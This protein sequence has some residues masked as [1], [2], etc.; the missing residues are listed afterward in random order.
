MSSDFAT[1]LP[2]IK[3]AI[4]HSRDCATDSLFSHPLFVVLKAYCV[5][6]HKSSIE[7]WGCFATNPAC[8]PP[9]EESCLSRLPWSCGW[10]CGSSATR[11][12]NFPNPYSLEASTIWEIV[13]ID[14]SE[15]TNFTIR[16][17]ACTSIR[18]CLFSKLT[19][20]EWWIWGLLP[21]VILQVISWSGRTVRKKFTARHDST[22]SA[23]KMLTLSSHISI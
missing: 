14:K 9:F 13:S 23:S 1:N 21:S 2:Y 12:V 18:C 8:A 4:H 17:V 5:S 6:R 7:S 22:N 20:P 19:G 11:R 3:T 15:W 10:S 16:P